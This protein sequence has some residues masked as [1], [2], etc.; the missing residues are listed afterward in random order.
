MYWTL[1]EE[2]FRCFER[3]HGARPI[4]YDDWFYCKLTQFLELLVYER[5]SLTY[6]PPPECAQKPETERPWEEGFLVLGPVEVYI[7]GD[8]QAAFAPEDND[9]TLWAEIVSE[10]SSAPGDR[11][12]VLEG[13]LIRRRRGRARRKP[14]SGS[15]R[16][17]ATT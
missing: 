1:R 12:A 13:I 4:R 6:G 15:E 16:K 17:S 9:S 14:G 2:T 3:A 8:V 7:E 10:V 5:L 11:V